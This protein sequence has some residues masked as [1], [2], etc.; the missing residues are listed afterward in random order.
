M[1]CVKKALAMLPFGSVITDRGGCFPAQNVFRPFP[2][3]NQEKISWGENNVGN[4]VLISSVKSS[5]DENLK[6]NLASASLYKIIQQSNTS[7]NN[8]I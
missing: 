5:A 6:K 3:H 7:P 1:G 2:S 4:G 8:I